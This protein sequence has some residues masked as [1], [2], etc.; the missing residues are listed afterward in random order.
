M[1]DIAIHANYLRSLCKS[2]Q[3]SPSDCRII[4]NHEG[5]EAYEQTGAEYPLPDL[6]CGAGREVRTQHGTAADRAAW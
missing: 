5:Q 4:N 3:S 6:W 2:D 1:S